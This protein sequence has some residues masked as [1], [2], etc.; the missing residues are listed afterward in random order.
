MLY[1]HQSVHSSNP[2]MTS[3][4][5]D[6]QYDHYS[7][8]VMTRSK[9]LWLQSSNVRRRAEKLATTRVMGI[10]D[11]YREGSPRIFKS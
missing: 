3:L 2:V 1:D 8:V 9:L 4:T 11:N 6:V 10:A 5:L 7:L